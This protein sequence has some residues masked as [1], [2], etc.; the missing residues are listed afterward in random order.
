[1]NA[2][3]MW[4]PKVIARPYD[5][6]RSAEHSRLRAKWDLFQSRRRGDRSE[7]VAQYERNFLYY[8]TFLPK[9]RAERAETDAQLAR[10][11]RAADGCD[12]AARGAVQA[13]R[14]AA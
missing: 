11:L 10:M 1:M 3:P 7:D 5:F 14:T 6:I 8:E 13:W 2:A 12:L 4:R 9:W